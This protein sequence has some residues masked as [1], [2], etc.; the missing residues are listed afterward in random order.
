MSA[1]RK[2]PR[3]Y[4]PRRAYRLYRTIT[5]DYGNQRVY[6]SC[7]GCDCWFPEELFGPARSD[8]RTPTRCS[9]RANGCRA[10]YDRVWRQQHRE[11]ILRQEAARREAINADPERRAA[12]KA[13]LQR[14]NQARDKELT[15]QRSKRHYE[16]IMAD[17]VRHAALLERRRL[18]YRLR[19][20][21]KGVKAVPARA[22]PIKYPIKYTRDYMDAAPL[23]Q[24][25]LE[26]MT[27]FDEQYLEF[28][29]RCGVS[30]KRIRE[31]GDGSVKRVSFPLVDKIL[32]TEG[33]TFLWE[34]YPALAAA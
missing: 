24:W 1:M 27:Q 19:V 15:R 30:E 9:Q 11:I 17:P 32:T 12:Y 4:T 31:I 23:R 2:E 21:R 10:A 29:Y 16:K 14:Y 22:N 7:S 33:S 34:L 5:D 13:R 18:D 3:L 8:G 28:S 26:R 6:R 25:I 20:E